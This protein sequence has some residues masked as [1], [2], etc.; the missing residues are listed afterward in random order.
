MTVFVLSFRIMGVCLCVL[1]GWMFACI[2]LYGMTEE[3]RNQ[4]LRGWRRSGSGG[5]T[6]FLGAAPPLSS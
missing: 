3:E 2:G 6:P 1:I 5:I 4:P